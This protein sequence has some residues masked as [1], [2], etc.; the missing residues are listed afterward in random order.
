MSHE[1]ATAQI[2][3]ARAL[4]EDSLV[5]LAPVTGTGPRA[6][7]VLLALA[8]G[9]GGHAGGEV[10]SSLVLERFCAAYGESPDNVTDA[11]R[12]S[13]DLANESLAEFSTGHPKLAGMGTTLVGCVIKAHRLHWISVGDSP[14]WLYRDA[15]LQRLNADH[16]MVPL[17][18][19]MVRTGILSRE[20]ASVD[21]RRSLLRS[22]V[23]GNTITLVDLRSKPFPLQARDI[24][25]LASDG[26]ETLAES[27]LAALLQDS[28]SVALTELAG[29]LLAAVEAAAATHQDNAS[30]ILY[31]C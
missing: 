19:D 3:G 21:A 8:D 23:T 14:L 10:A 28:E 30:V 11:L 29:A 13:L 18:D 15:T 5:T 6:G 2:V 9:M 7:E 20:A 27:E 1:V 25:L 16:S 24:V 26:I 22:A 17:L 12:S 4:Q 31:R